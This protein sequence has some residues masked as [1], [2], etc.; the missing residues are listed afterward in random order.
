[1]RFVLLA[2]LLAGFIPFS[3]LGQASDVEKKLPITRVPHQGSA[4]EAYFSPDGKSLICQG[5]L[6]DDDGY[7]EYTMRLDGTNIRRINDQGVDA[8]SYFFP[9]GDRLV[10]VSTKDHLDPK[11]GNFSDPKDYPPGAEIYTSDLNG[12][13]VCRL[14]D[15]ETYDCEVSVSPN[16][17]WI[18]FTRQINGKLD[19]WRMHP[20]GVY[21]FQITHTDDWQEGGAFYMPDSKTILYRAWKIE[22]E[23][24]GRGLPMTIFTIRDDGT[25]LTKIT[26]DD[27]TNW[28][29]FPAPD[30]RHFVFVKVL[31]PHNYEI[32]L[33]DLDTKEQKRLTFNDGF[34]GFP[35]ISPD[36]RKMLFASSRGGVPGERKLFLFWMDIS[37]L[38]IGPKN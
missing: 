33:M 11:A 22:A 27:G 18:L 12:K 9:T 35:A 34:D 32:Y 30:G 23:G 4:A 37:S 25:G 21:E 8:C 1:M 29:P 15:N 7:H 24:K 6:P 20:E 26:D 38:K 13:Q 28:A 17:K 36:G 19:L 3:V 31:P 2:G 10:W 16:G 14:T 5:K